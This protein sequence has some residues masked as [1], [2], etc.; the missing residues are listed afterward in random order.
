M[1][2]LGNDFVIIDGRKN[3]I[4]L[5]AALICKMANRKTGIGFDT[6]RAVTASTGSRAVCIKN[7]HFYVTNF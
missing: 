5:S 1:D 4:A 6:T 7:F 2:G 3:K